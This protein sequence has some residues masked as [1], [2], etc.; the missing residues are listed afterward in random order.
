MKGLVF[1]TTEGFHPPGPWPV[2]EWLGLYLSC[3]MEEGSLLPS[4]SVPR[5]LP[6][7]LHCAHG[8]P[9]YNTDRVNCFPA[10]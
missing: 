8:C 10:Q 9:G 7:A 1:P 4:G 3:V 5:W 6:W 2:V